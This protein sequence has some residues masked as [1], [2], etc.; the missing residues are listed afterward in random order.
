M[1]PIRST[2][3]RLQPKRKVINPSRKIRFLF[4][5]ILNTFSGLAAIFLGK[6]LL[7]LSDIIANISGYGLGLLIS[8]SLNKNWTFQYKGNGNTAFVRFLLVII[9]AYCS[10]LTTVL[11][12][13]HF[14]VNSYVSQAL[15]II[16][17][18]IISYF[19]SQNYVF[20]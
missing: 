1:A 8:F 7:G 6:A 3:L 20:K 9:I 2:I 4:V 10:N 18:T 14:G 16:P 12:F 11:I 19:G 17:Y 5:G 15:G 13:I